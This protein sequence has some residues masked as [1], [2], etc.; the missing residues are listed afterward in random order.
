MNPA[1]SDQLT[2]A[3]RSQGGRLQQQEEQ[4]SALQQGVT[5]LG[6]SQDGF[7]SA[8][9]TQVNHLAS[10]IQQMLG[11]LQRESSS[12]DPGIATHTAAA[13]TPPVP[14]FH[15][16]TL[17]LSPPEKFSGEPGQCRS[18]IVQCS[19]HY[20]QLPSA[21]PTEKSKVAF[22]VSHLTGRAAAW[23]TAEWA[24]ES[25]ICESRRQF[26]EA[27]RV[28]FDS[29]ALGRE[30]ARKL[31]SIEQ[32]M[33]SVADYAIRFRTIATDSGWNAPALFDTFVKGLSDN[34]Q[35]LLVP[36]DL[37]DDLDSMIALAVRTDNRIKDRRKDGLQA[38]VCQDSS[39]GRILPATHVWEDSAHRSSPATQSMVFP[40]PSEEPMRLG[41]AK[42]S[43]E[44]RRRR[45]QEGRCFY[46]GQPGHLLSA[47]PTKEKNHQKKGGTLA[48]RS[49]AFTDT[50]R[51]LTNIQ[52]KHHDISVSLG[53]LI[54]SGADE[55]LMDWGFAQRIGIKTELL[56]QPLEASALDGT[57][58]FRVTHKTEPLQVCIKDHHEQMSFRLF[59][60]A[61]HPIVLG[62]PWLKQHNPHIDWCSGRVMGWG[63][64]CVGKC[65]APRE[66][67]EVGV[68]VDLNSASVN[69][70]S[71]MGT[72]SPD[73]TSVPK[74]YH[75]LGEV[76]SKSKATSLPPHRPYDCSIELISGAPIP[77]G[78]LYSISGPERAA[79]TEYIETSLK[80][81]LIRPS[82]SPAGAGFFFC[83]E[84][85]WLS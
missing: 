17:R 16:A 79:M 63:G 84:K 30:A 8:M 38:A 21:F 35:D 27:L 53:V 29:T 61:Q 81:G 14:A 54:D 1:D 77:K 42:L 62:F 50:S 25:P 68:M 11:Y 2:A 78:K 51:S 40:D 74:C 20:E 4:M 55:S 85:R 82:S 76:F 37:P 66:R 46:C 70:I 67:R 52:V 75:D 43:T 9:T 36:L 45:L 49:P 23:A 44:E 57:L 26:E 33:D 18:F 7:K 47:C 65:V 19:L 13:V 15:A 58:I 22:M 3:I 71:D 64:S 48:S 72:N 39:R 6:N 73:L 12:P 80:A 10:Q 24:R 31:S 69:P 28:V 41:R 60:S 56:S 83:R 32:G 59:H 5:E 34:I